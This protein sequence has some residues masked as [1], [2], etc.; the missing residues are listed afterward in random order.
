MSTIVS[1]P[2][3]IELFDANDRPLVFDKLSLPL[4]V[5]WRDFIA[6]MIN[7]RRIEIARI[8]GLLHN[9][10][11]V[12]FNQLALVR[13]HNESGK[14]VAIGHGLGFTQEGVE[15][16]VLTDT[17]PG[18]AETV[19]HLTEV[20]IAQAALPA[21]RHNWQGTVNLFLASHE[22][23]L[24]GDGPVGWGYTDQGRGNWTRTFS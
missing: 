4:Q 13:A 3:S 18:R 11:S 7:E 14:I 6:L 8:L 15:L 20:L 9:Q 10:P 24:V 17:A 21:Q 5:A 12:L 22:Q 16:R 1:A 19:R 2:T 23:Q